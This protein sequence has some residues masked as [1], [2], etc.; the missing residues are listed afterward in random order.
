MSRERNE[1]LLNRWIELWN[2]NLTLIDEI[3]DPGFVGHFPPTTSRSNE[4]RGVQALAEWIRMT[5][6]LFVDVRLTLEVDPLIDGDRVVG[7]WIFRG[8]YQGGLPGATSAPGTQIAFSGTDI[9]RM[10]NEKIV[11]YWVS[12]DGMYL[13]QQLGVIPS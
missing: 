7:R 11:E 4:V 5:L 8:T 13:M 2:G 12:S 10:A 6:A 3:V 9:L 1:T